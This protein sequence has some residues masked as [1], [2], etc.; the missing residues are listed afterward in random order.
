MLSIPQ[1]TQE[2][3]T[4]LPSGRFVAGRSGNPGGRPRV[5]G[6]VQALA[7]SHTAEAIATLIEIAGDD[8]APSAARVAAANALLDRAWGKPAASVTICEESSGA[9]P[10][11]FRAALDAAVAAG[12]PAMVSQLKN[13]RTIAN[14]LAVHPDSGFIQAN[15]SDSAQQAAWR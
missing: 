4:R 5:L 1:N 2:Q 13:A 9:S 6:D 3:V 10:S 7:R 11:E 14:D 12:L 15:P 8:S